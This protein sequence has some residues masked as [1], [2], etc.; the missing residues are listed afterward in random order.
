M[1]TIQTLFEV[2]NIAEKITFFQFNFFAE[3]EKSTGK[4]LNTLLNSVMS[5]SNE[6]TYVQKLAMDRLMDMVFLTKLR[7]RQALTILI[8]N[9]IGQDLSLNTRRIRSLYYLFEYEK[10]DIESILYE[11]LS[12]M[13]AELVAEASF[14]LGLIDMRQGLLSTDKILSIASLEKSRSKFVFAG[15]SIENRQD[16]HILGKVV[17]LT[18]NLI[19][20]FSSSIKTGLKEIGDLLFK[21]E[22]FSFNFKDGPN[23]IG[24][25]R[26]LSGLVKVSEQN[27]NNWLDYRTGLSSLYHE[28]ALI[29]DQEIKGRLSLSNLSSGFLEK[30]NSAFFEPFFAL[31]FS[32]EKLK[33][34]LRLKELP[35]DDP[36]TS[37]LKNLL[38]FLGSDPKK[39]A[40]SESLKGQLRN[41]FPSV[42]VENIE[43]LELKYADENEQ[44]QIFKIYSELA[45]PSSA[46]LDDNIIKSSLL[47][48]SN[49]LYL[50]DYSEDDRNTFVAS[51]LE[52]SDYSMKDQTRR[53]RSETGKS[54]GEI[55]ILIQ[56][57]DQLPISIIEALNLSY[58]DKSYIVQHIDKIF[59]YD[60]NGLANNYIIVYA[61]VKKFGAFYNRYRDFV[62]AHDFKYPLLSMKEDSVLPFTEL[63]KFT[64][65]HNRNDKEVKVHHIVINLT[66]EK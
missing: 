53:S 49:R 54:A 16:A 10:E 64:I 58:V 19:N 28:Y 45:T 5:D 57:K 46:R 34:E 6:N 9:W 61:N 35:P 51:L 40:S 20:N 41:L 21:M 52:M 59:K 38:G 43:S 4:D 55:D 13:E 50:G 42:S 32:P 12:S 18:I 56:D 44:T 29:K 27:P 15:Q 26:I 24:F 2:M 48:Q 66:D 14:H 17:E 3:A 8:D 65:V 1:A 11:Y 30:I 33:I 37:F 62:K 7:P 47:L 31:N 22:G 60:A 63:R 23:Y 25:Y 36:E 39:K